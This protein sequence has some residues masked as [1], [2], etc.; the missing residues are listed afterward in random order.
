MSD[1]L[2]S[3]SE[4]TARLVDALAHEGDQGL[5]EVVWSL[6]S[7]TSPSSAEKVALARQ[8]VFG[9]RQMGRVTLWRA[10][11]PKS[12]NEGRALTDDE[13]ALLAE[14]DAPWFDPENAGEFIVWLTMA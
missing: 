10:P 11:W 13:V 8:A 5:W 4:V 12:A 6:N 7:D 1:E 2:P 3:V 14:T 9:L